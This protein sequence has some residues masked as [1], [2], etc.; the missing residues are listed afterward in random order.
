[1]KPGVLQ[2]YAFILLVC[3]FVCFSAFICISSSFRSIWLQ[4]RCNQWTLAKWD[5][6]MCSIDEQLFCHRFEGLHSA[7]VLVLS[8]RG[9]KEAG[10]GG[11]WGRHRVGDCTSAPGYVTDRYALETLRLNFKSEALFQKQKV[12][13]TFLC[14]WVHN[15]FKMR[16]EREKERKWKSTTFH[17]V[18]YWFKAL[19]KLRFEWSENNSFGRVLNILFAV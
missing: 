15:T 3:W 10:G 18:G 19:W 4:G 14:P 11:R 16:R 2:L 8:I 7:S 1:M 5:V 9:D 6:E 12:H 13:Q 17:S